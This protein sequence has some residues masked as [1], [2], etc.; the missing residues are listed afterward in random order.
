VKN[1]LTETSIGNSAIQTL[2]RA[3]GRPADSF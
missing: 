1:L 2:G 3:E